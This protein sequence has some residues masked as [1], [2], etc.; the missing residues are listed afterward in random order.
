MQLN[1]NRSIKPDPLTVDCFFFVTGLPV[2]I[3]IWLMFW[4]ALQK[5]QDV[6]MKFNRSISVIGCATN[7]SGLF[8]R[9][10]TTHP[11]AS[12]TSRIGHDLA[13]ASCSSF[14]PVIT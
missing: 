7:I 8:H 14:T 11:N 12:W 10:F 13:E 3:T 2:K 4:Q 5:K 1:N 9:T 6:I